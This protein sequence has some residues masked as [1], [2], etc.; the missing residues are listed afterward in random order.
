ML[1]RGPFLWTCIALGCAL[2]VVAGVRASAVEPHLSATTY[3]LMQPESFTVWTIQVAVRGGRPVERVSVEFPGDWVAGGPTYSG[4]VTPDQGAKFQVQVP[5]DAKR[6]WVFRMR[7]HG[8][9]ERTYEVDLEEAA[10]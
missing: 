2:G 8:D 6:P 3:R 10:K 9:A 5:N 4:V 1:R 7:Q